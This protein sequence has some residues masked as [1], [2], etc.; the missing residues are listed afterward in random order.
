MQKYPEILRI[1]KDSFDVFALL[2]RIEA[3]KK[4]LAIAKDKH[5]LLLLGTTGCG[6]T[7]TIYYLKGVELLEKAIEVER[8]DKRTGKVSRKREN[9]IDADN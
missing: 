6:K 1:F 7:T 3:S 8:V 9:V 5:L 2:E 4:S